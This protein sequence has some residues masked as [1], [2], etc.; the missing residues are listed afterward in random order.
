M[1][2]DPAVELGRRVTNALR[3]KREQ[4]GISQNELAQRCNMSRTGLRAIELG[5]NSPTFVSL[6]L[7]CTALGV[8][9][10]EIVAEMEKQS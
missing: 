8:S 7:I 4:L 9:L 6:C 10:G 2:D 1:S 3:I 5:I